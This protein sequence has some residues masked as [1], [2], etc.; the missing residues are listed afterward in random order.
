M[1]FIKRNIMKK[2][3][4]IYITSV[5]LLFGCSDSFL[6]LSPESNLSDKTFFQTEDQF[7]RATAGVYEAVRSTVGKSGFLMGEERSDNAH[8]VRNEVDRG[9]RPAEDIADFTDDAI[10]PLTNQFYNDCFSGIA[11]A[12]TVIQRLHEKSFSE[13]FNNKIEG[14]AKFLRAY[15]YFELVRYYGGVSLNLQIVESGDDKA[16]LPRSSVEEV[17]AQIVADLEDAERMLSNPTFNDKGKQSGRAS[18]GSAKMLLARVLMTKPT[19]D[20]AK[21]E[22]LLKEITKMGYS[23]IDYTDLF[24]PNYKNSKESIFEVQFKQGDDG[25][26]SSFIYRMMPLTNDGKAIT[27]VAG[28]N[29][30]SNGGY[31]IPT[32]EMVNS[33]EAGDKRLD[34]SIAVAVGKTDTQSGIMRID[35]VLKVGDPE[36]A[37]YPSYCYFVNKYRN[38]HAKIDN[39]DDNWPVYRYADVYLSLAECLVEQNRASEAI[40]YVNEVRKRAGLAD[41]TAVTAKV[42]ADERRHEFAFENKRW[43]DLIRTGEA[44]TVMNAYGVKMKAL[45]PYIE[46]RAYN[47]TKERLIFPLPYREL[48]INSKLTQNPGY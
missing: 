48:Q 21:A 23:L 13:E 47:V 19:R 32:Q 28:S 12:N 44:I 9:Q 36:I 38:P 25:Q 27:G 30:T 42:V 4:S 40:P 37:N 34:R 31:V 3:I 41:V 29:N 8:Y 46:A 6:D 18:K 17:Y 22:T 24:D 1:N 2:R 16:F 35:A 15:F 26:Q 39:T 7:E 14:Q 5:L 33:Y 11:K 10:N 45:Y 43:H 20:Y